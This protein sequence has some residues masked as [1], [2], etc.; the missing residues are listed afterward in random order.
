MKRSAILGFAMF[1][2]SCAGDSPGPPDV[3]RIAAMVIKNQSQYAMVDL[4]MHAEASYAAAPNVLPE[5]MDVGDELL[6]YG[7]G[8]RYFTFIR[9]K[10]V[11]GPLLAFTTRDAVRMERN[12]GYEMVLFDESFRVETSTYVRP[13]RY[14]GLIVGDPGS[15]C[16]WL[17]PTETGTTCKNRQQN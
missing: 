13:D 6:Y 12:F 16:D 4:R 3:G 11:M 17:P 2:A 8:D 10:Y 5:A 15:P 14:Q 9:E 1:A 7:S